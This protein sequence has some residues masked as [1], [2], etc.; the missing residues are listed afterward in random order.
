VLTNF[1]PASVPFPYTCDL[2]VPKLMRRS[3]S[4]RFITFE[5]MFATGLADAQ[6]QNRIPEDVEVIDNSPEEIRE[7]ALEMLAEEQG[8]GSIAPPNEVHR[9]RQRFNDILREHAAFAGSRISGSFL[10]RHQP[11]V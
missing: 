5:E 4:D 8:Q 1:T 7:A 2:M 10:L 11:L 9:L 3:G 6:F